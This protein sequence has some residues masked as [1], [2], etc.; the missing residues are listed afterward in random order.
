M[1]FY[2]VTVLTIVEAQS[3]LY[4]D[5]GMRKRYELT[6]HGNSNHVVK[7]IKYLN[8][9]IHNWLDYHGSSKN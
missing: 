5:G 4:V 3:L 9:S 2:L 8:T 7:L 6:L 1:C